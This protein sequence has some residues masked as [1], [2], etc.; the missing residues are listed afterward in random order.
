MV[1]LYSALNKERWVLG[2]ASHWIGAVTEIHTPDRTALV[3]S[4]CLDLIS[5]LFVV[6]QTS[7]ISVYVM[8]HIPNF[9]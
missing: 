7:R 2:T 6:I 8:L 1:A 9:H 3:A 5:F 4:K